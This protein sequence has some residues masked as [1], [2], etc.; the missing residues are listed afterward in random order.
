[1][2]KRLLPLCMLLVF[3]LAGC[4]Q[5]SDP[6]A[7][8]SSSS[9]PD[10]LKVAVS[11]LPQKEFVRQVAGDLVDI[12]VLV[13]PGFSPEQY[14]PSP[15]D[16]IAFEDADIYFTIDVPVEE[17]QLEGLIRQADDM[18]VVS[19]VQAYK[20]AGMDDVLF[21][22]DHAHEAEQTHDADAHSHEGHSH[23]VGSRD[24]HSWLS[25]T[26]VIAMVEVISESLQ[27]LD[28]ENA[29]TYQANAQA[30]IEELQTLDQDIRHAVSQID[31]PTFLCYHPAYGYLAD[32]YDLRM[33]P[34]EEDGHEASPT[35]LQEIIDLAKEEHI[36]IVFYQSEI[37]SQQA[38]A[39]AN[40]IDGETAMLEPLAED[41]IAN[42]RHMVD[43]ILKAA[44]A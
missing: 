30:Y 36:Q 28:P 1:M 21:G 16:M 17:T 33:I 6:V 18:K 11:I 14:E 39:L 37:D 12:Q 32:D 25:P 10:K 9:E 34:L 31:N 40:E 42:M 38:E 8:E 24:H 2:K 23:D 15:Q 43:A 44:A 41:Y 19:L 26:R 20:D 7:S 5:G 35:R 3:A 13:P 27:D 4:G 22:V 29:A